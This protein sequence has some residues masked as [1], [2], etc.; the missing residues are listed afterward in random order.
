MG[1]GRTFRNPWWLVFGSTLALI[2]G[3]GPVIV[4]TFGVFLKPVIDEFGWSRGTVSAGL[5]AYQTAGAIA[6]PLAGKLVD[7][8]GIRR[9]TLLSI[10]A[11]SLSIAVISQ[12]P[13]YSPIFLM[14]YGLCGLA[15]SGQAPLSYAKAISAQ[16]ETRRGLALG[17]AMSGVGIGTALMPQLARLLLQSFGWR[18]AYVGL[19]ILTLVTAFPC[20]LLFVSAPDHALNRRKPATDSGMTLGA[21][22]VSFRFWSLAGAVFLV[23]AVTNGTTTHIVP[24]LTDRGLSTRVGTLA[25]T[26]VGLA[27]IAGRVLGGH[28]VDRF[29]APYITAC[30][31]LVPLVGIILLHFGSAPQF[32]LLGAICVGVGLGSEIALMGFLVGPYFGL[33]G[34]G[35]IYGYLMAAFLVGAG[36]GAWIMGVC[37]DATHS[38]DLAFVGFALS[39]IVASFL[40]CRLGPYVY[41]S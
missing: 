38:Y 30:F 41:P 27:M 28:L 6:A 4:F 1:S 35:E 7:R 10:V 23:S 9:V 19:G 36:L 5:T 39:L 34:Y 33:R 37:Y 32:P 17:I 2:V 22:K 24:L 26:F 31:F 29:F 11:F 13:S 3:N 15:G 12:T 16:F 40:V 8:W 25:L 18:D 20:V 21:L 14:L